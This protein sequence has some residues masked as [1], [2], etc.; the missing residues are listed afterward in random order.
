MKGGISPR[1]AIIKRSTREAIEAAGGLEVVAQVTNAGRSQLSRCQS[2][3]EVDTLSLRDALALD[4]LTLGR[5]GP[6]IA[7]AMARLLNQVLVELPDGEAALDH[8]MTGVVR[9]S[10]ELG[11]LATC[12]SESLADG[13]FEPKEAITA[14]DEVHHI[15]KVTAELRLL[16]IAIRDGEVRG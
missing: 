3:N 14:L 12:V 16:L 10:A 9:L 4:E 1:L 15:N 13:K 2:Q 6:F 11:H 7:T 8:V 5:G